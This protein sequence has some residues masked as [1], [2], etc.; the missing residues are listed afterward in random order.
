MRAIHAFESAKADGVDATLVRP[1]NWNDDHVISGGIISVTD[2]DYGAVA[3]CTTGN[4]GTDNTDAF[5]DAIDTA[6]ASGAS[7]Y[8]PPA[9]GAGY[10]ID[11]P[12]DVH[13]IN[14]LTI[15]GGV[16]VAPAFSIAINYPTSGSIIYANTGGTLFCGI[17]SNNLL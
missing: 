15:F 11:S 1:G 6:V 2:S 4:N 12:L 14:S 10:R 13:E 5:Q 17:G 9:I 16:G 8:I 3:D 7:L